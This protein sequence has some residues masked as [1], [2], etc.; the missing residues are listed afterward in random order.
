V[1]SLP[2]AREGMGIGYRIG[3]IFRLSSAQAARDMIG[4]FATS[5]EIMLPVYLH[6]NR[7]LPA[8]PCIRM[9]TLISK[10][11]RLSRKKTVT[12]IDLDIQ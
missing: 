4:R 3:I 2:Q 10:V 8:M 5:D 12:Q 1:N 9:L 7:I 6:F 11:S